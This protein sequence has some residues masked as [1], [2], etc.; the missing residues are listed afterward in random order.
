MKK[1]VTLDIVLYCYNV[2]LI[3]VFI[4]I[5]VLNIVVLKEALVTV[6]FFSSSKNDIHCC[7]SSLKPDLAH[8]LVKSVLV[9]FQLKCNILIIPF[10]ILNNLKLFNYLHSTFEQQT[11]PFFFFLCTDTNLL[12]LLVKMSVMFESADL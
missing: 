7:L 5:L 10:C 8:G 4:F 11:F 12:H 6:A 2:Y 9:Q 1:H 3:L